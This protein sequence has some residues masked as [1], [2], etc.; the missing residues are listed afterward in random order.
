MDDDTAWKLLAEGEYGFL[1]MN[2][3]D[4]YGYGIPI[5]YALSRRNIYFH[6]ATEGYKLVCLKADDRVSFCVVGRTEVIPSGFT[7]IYESV[8][9]FGRIAGGLSDE[10]RLDALRLLGAKYCPGYAEKAEKY[11]A[12]SFRRTNVLRLDI[13]EVTAKCKRTKK[14]IL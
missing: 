12:A 10:E 5:S 9:A 6:C 3:A 8:I 1:A 4:G 2:G 14:V 11:I 7:T 13:E